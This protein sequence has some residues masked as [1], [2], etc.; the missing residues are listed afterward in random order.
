MAGVGSCF[1]TLRAIR[2]RGGWGTHFLAGTEN[3]IP[4]IFVRAYDLFDCPVDP[5]TLVSRAGED[6]G[7]IGDHSLNE[8]RYQ[9]IVKIRVWGKHFDLTSY[10]QFRAI[11]RIESQLAF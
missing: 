7:R 9:R 3:G 8:V 10:A 11:Q 2:L 5:S 1:P 4:S 6:A